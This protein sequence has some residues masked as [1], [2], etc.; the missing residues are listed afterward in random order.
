MSV[1]VVFYSRYS[2][3]SL[4]FLSEIEKIMDVR[5][6]CI[7]NED[8]RTKVLEE[9]E[10]YNI[11]CVPSVL[12]FHSN[13]FLEKQTGEEC[14]SWLEKVKPQ[15][16]QKMEEVVPIEK[17]SKKELLSV[18]DIKYETSRKMDTVPLVLKEEKSDKNYVDDKIK[19]DRE[20]Q[21]QSNLNKTNSQDNIMSLAQQMQKQREL[22]VKD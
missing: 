18:D 21:A 9:N 15:E 7:D 12:I 20:N 4:S 13:G 11:E 17:T 6:L 22:E 16:T 8:V 1:V 14:F 3:S 19:E 10:N 5:K 2:Q